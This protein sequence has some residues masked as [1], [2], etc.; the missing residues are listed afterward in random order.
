MKF[1][2]NTRALLAS[3]GAEGMLNEGVEQSFWMLIIVPMVAVSP[4]LVG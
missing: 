1:K 4:V 2:V 3:Y